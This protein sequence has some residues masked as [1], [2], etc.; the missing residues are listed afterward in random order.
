LGPE[1]KNE[2][3]F[4]YEILNYRK[5]GSWIGFLTMEFLTIGKLGPE[6][7]MTKENKEKKI[8]M[9]IEIWFML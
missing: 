7:M 1:W 4:Y 2:W 8:N 3:I 6:W 9:I 5:V